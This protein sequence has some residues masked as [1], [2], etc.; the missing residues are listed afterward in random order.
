MSVARI[1]RDDHA[2]LV[3]TDQV[4]NHG[5]FVAGFHAFP[6][7]EYPYLKKFDILLAALVVFAVVQPGAG[8][9][10][11]D[12]AG[13]DRR[14]V[15]H[16]VFMFERPAQRDRNDL[17]LAVRMQV[18]PHSR[19]DRVVVQNP[20]RPEM[21]ARGIVI[22]R[23]TERMVGLQPSVIEITPRRSFVQQYIHNSEILIFDI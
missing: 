5:I 10:H 3:R 18:E 16:A 12:F 6:I 21:D 9:H 8:A 4:G 20:Q 23:K 22:T 11:L 7:G 15:P 19:S 2:E 13:G 14:N 1:R 17:H